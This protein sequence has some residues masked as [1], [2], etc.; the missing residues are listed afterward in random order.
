LH[1]LFD[2]ENRKVF[3]PDV[4]ASFKFCVLVFGKAPR[5]LEPPAAPA[6]AGEAASGPHPEPMPKSLAVSIPEPIPELPQAQPSRCAFYLHSLDELDTPGRVLTLSAQDFQRVNPNTGAAPI[7]RNQRDADITLAL[8]ARHPVLVQHGA[9][10]DALGQQPDIKAWP[11]KYQRMFDMTNDSQ[12]FQTAKELEA[13]GWRRAPLNR[14]EK[15]SGKAIAQA[16]PL[17]EGKMVQMWDH[18]AA[19][20]VVNHANLHR[21]A[22]QESI[23]Q[24]EKANPARFPVPQYWVE[25]TEVTGARD[26]CLGFKDVT[27]PTNMRTMIA[28]MLPR[29]AYGN[30]LP[31]LLPSLEQ[32]DLPYCRVASLLLANFS[33]FAFDFVARQKVQGQ[34]LNWFTV[35]QLPVIAPE[36]FDERLPP[37]FAAAMRAAQRMNGHHPHPTVADFVLPQVLALSYT[38]HDLAPFAQD[39]GYVDAAGAVLPPLQWNDAERRA[40]MAALDAVF[41]YLYGVGADDASYI[42]NTFPI[43]REQDM[44]LFGRFATH[45]AVLEALGLLQ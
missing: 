15:Q 1:A 18:R 34:H 36:R 33:S 30:T 19:D 24:A 11:V 41:F 42:M 29:G 37:N 4:H 5:M 2:F 9:V 20:V 44:Q 3:F 17:C 27:A 45:D 39:L 28:A 14:W 16:L 43:V 10:S 21:A 23:S 12:L 31:V 25:A 6:P 38:A 40:R 32:S 26:Y 8:Y 7:F 35:E 22:Q 13:Q